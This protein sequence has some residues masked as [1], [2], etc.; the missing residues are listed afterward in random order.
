MGLAS[1]TRVTSGRKF[2]RAGRVNSPISET[3]EA[4]AAR[5]TKQRERARGVDDR[6]EVRIEKGG[7]AVGAGASDSN[8]TPDTDS[9]GGVAAMALAAFSPLSSPTTTWGGSEE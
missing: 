4:K 9:W 5:D 2:T 8:A 7:E 3:P 1:P 6:D